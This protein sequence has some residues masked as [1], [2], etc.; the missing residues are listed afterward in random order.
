MKKNVWILA[1]IFIL[2]ALAISVVDSYASDVSIENVR[3]HK[4]YPTT[5]GVRGLVRNLENHPIKGYVKIKFL[6]ARGDIVKTVSA[7]VNSLDPFNPG[8][9]APF[10]YYD[11]PS[12]F[13]G[14]TNFQVIFKDR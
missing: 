13:E 1:F 2:L 10:E 9:A 7:Y 12:E 6:N 14:V 5:W 3:I 8:Q 11:N 4:L